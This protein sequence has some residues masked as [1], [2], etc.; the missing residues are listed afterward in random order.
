MIAKNYRDFT[1]N[2]RIRTLPTESSYCSGFDPQFTC[3]CCVNWLIGLFGLM[4]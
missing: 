2:A 1:A 3:S 4:F